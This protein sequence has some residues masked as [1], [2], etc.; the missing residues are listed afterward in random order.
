MKAKKITFEYE[1]TSKAESITS[2]S[3]ATQHD[4]AASTLRS[5]LV[6]HPRL[7][8]F[9][10]KIL[11][12]RS[13]HID[14][15]RTLQ[16]RCSSGW[17]DISR[18]EIHV[19]SASAGLRLRTADATAESRT[20]R[21]GKS[22][23]PG[24]IEIL[25]LPPE[26]IFTIHIPYN[27][28]DD[29]REI[30]V[31]LDVT[32]FTPNG[33]FEFL[34]NPSIKTELP[35]DV[36]VHDF[37]KSS[38]LF[39]RFQIRSSTGIPLQ[40]LNV[41]LEGTDQFTVQP[42]PC[43][44]T[45]LLVFQS[46]PA[47]IMYKIKQIY[48]SDPETKPG[49]QTVAEEL[50]LTLTIDYGCIDEYAIVAAETS[51]G[52]ALSESPFAALSPL[53][54]R[55]FSRNLREA[56]SVKQFSEVALLSELR[57]PDYLSM[58]WNTLLDHLPTPLCATLRSW[59]QSWHE[60]HKVAAI[61]HLGGTGIA[62][63]DDDLSH[64]IIMNVPLPRLHILQTVS[65]TL[66][67]S[68]QNVF[69]SGSLIPATVSI[70]H[71][72]QW[73]TATAFK[74]IAATPDTSLDFVFEIDAPNDAWLIGGQRRTRFTAKED[75]VKSWTFMIMPLRVGRLLLP[76][77]DIRALGKGTETVSCETDLRSLGETV[78]VIA[79]LGSTTV[80]LTDSSTG[81]EAILMESER[82]QV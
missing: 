20:A 75:E 65:I 51:F 13:L 28:E 33:R 61:S 46:Q 56:T 25:E 1:A 77:V 23:T 16:I 53:L 36:N 48:G 70:K 69:P 45:P 17:N 66:P 76:T 7:E 27:L 49:R 38:L 24:M 30:S 8:S 26:N 15:T 19:R 40:I 42:P 41:F 80:A 43:A 62:A 37:F 72:R 52:K 10:A 55:T 82:R 47:T 32:Y 50:P 63:S 22:N 2:L 3:L 44:M 12:S 58:K 60:G 64:R 11:L 34:S 79:D 5:R 31:R 14:K 67:K 4:Q 6:C 74:S 21:L 78:V 29:L 71:T 57:I 35:V 54:L 73:D 81:G 39:S 68:D 9:D 59:L 18:A